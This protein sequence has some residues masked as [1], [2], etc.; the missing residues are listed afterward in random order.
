MNDKNTSNPQQIRNTP[1][2]G[3]NQATTC[4]YCGEGGKLDHGAHLRCKYLATRFLKRTAGPCFRCEVKPRLLTSKFGLCR[5]C[6]DDHRKE[7]IKA[8]NHR[9]YLRKKANEKP[10]A[11]PCSC[12]CGVILE[13][14]RRKK[15]ATKEC[16]ERA[17]NDRRKV[18]Q[19][20]ERAR[21]AKAAE[22]RQPKKVQERPY[23]EARVQVKPAAHP[24]SDVVI[25][26]SHVTVT[27]IPPS[28]VFGRGLRNLFGDENG[29]TWS[30][31]D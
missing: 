7:S 15:Y 20:A 23:A 16:M 18:Q 31:I 25:V 2:R 13:D 9:W 10:P 5:E 30:A 22:A 27:R 8:A 4:R 3:R 12:G 1:P 26:P 28:P 6:S 19:R 21:I 11:L 14:R 24:K 17:D 29:N